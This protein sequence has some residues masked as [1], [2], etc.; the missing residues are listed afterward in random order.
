MRRVFARSL[1]VAAAAAAAS[2][3][4]TGGF[5]QTGSSLAISTWL[6]VAR[7]RGR[8]APPPCRVFGD[9][10]FA[11]FGQ[12]RQ[13]RRPSEPRNAP[14]SKSS[15]PP[16]SWP[17]RFGG[18]RETFSRE[19]APFNS[20][21]LVF[22]VREYDNCLYSAPLSNCPR[23]YRATLTRMRNFCARPAASFAR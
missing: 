3:L 14:L 5:S 12:V 9:R 15:A 22:H 23:R 11:R 13:R 7:A 2:E 1:L 17:T 10:L 18:E 19:E 20:G 21:P 16:P 6:G 8:G 4:I